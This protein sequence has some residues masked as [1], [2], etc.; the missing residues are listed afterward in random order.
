MVTPDTIPLLTLSTFGYVT[1]HR[2]KLDM[3]L[4][5]YFE[6]RDEKSIQYLRKQY[7]GD[8]TGFIDSL[9]TSL[10]E[11]LGRYYPIVDL[12]L[13]LDP[14][15][16]PNSNTVGIQMSGS[17]TLSE[18]TFDLSAQLLLRGDKMTAVINAIENG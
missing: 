10:A 5:Q 13:R 14:S 9:Q 11:Y 17:Y 3:A 2:E 6:R 4:A 15:I 8:I 7:G 12:N 16:D 18:G 1:N